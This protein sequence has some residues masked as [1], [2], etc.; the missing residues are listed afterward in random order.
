M[1]TVPTKDSTASSK[2][3][4]FGVVLIS[5][6]FLAENVFRDSSQNVENHEEVLSERIEIVKFVQSGK[7]LPK[8]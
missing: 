4:A 3:Q 5:F 8:F 6:Y 2:K 7:R 1:K